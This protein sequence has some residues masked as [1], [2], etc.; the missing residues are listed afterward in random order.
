M[1]GFGTNLERNIIKRA[2]NDLA[3]LGK[4][5]ESLADYT[6]KKGG[7]NHPET[8]YNN[9]GMDEALLGNQ[10]TPKDFEN[11]AKSR[12]FVPIEE[13]ADLPE[14][15]VY[16][17]E[18]SNEQG[19][20]RQ[21]QEPQGPADDPY[22]LK[23]LITKLFT[24]LDQEET[25]DQA[26]HDRK[27][28]RLLTRANSFLTEYQDILKKGFS[29][30]KEYAAVR[31]SFK[32]NIGDLVYYHNKVEVLPKIIAVGQ[33]KPGQFQGEPV[34]EVEKDNRRPFR[35][36]ALHRQSVF[37]PAINPDLVDAEGSEE[38]SGPTAFNPRTGRQER[39]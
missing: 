38:E 28:N 32:N 18:D 2:E 23:P 33:A 19:F 31:R 6:G 21:E 20:P 39:V 24:G 29:P 27:V 5:K 11:R 12:S 16:E 30:R 15:D 3:D 8:E 25:T 13:V 1:G 34:K 37:R 26:K 36:S 7:A 10:D 4:K 9:P 14:S 22:E 35:G 17:T